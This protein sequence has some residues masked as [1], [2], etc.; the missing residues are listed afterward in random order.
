[1]NLWRRFK[2]WLKS[3]PPVPIIPQNHVPETDKDK[4]QTIIRKVNIPIFRW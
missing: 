3:K 2:A 4:K 1:M